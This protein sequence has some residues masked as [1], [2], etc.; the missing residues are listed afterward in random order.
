MSLRVIVSLLLVLVA[1]MLGSCAGAGIST[2]DDANDE[3]NVITTKPHFLSLVK[4]L[5][6]PRVHTII[7]ESHNADDE[8]FL[9]KESFLAQRRDRRHEFEQRLRDIRWKLLSNPDN[10]RLKKKAQ[11]YEKKIKELWSEELNERQHLEHWLAGQEKLDRDTSDT[12]TD[13][14]SEIA[15]VARSEVDTSVK[16]ALRRRLRRS[17]SNPGDQE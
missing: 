1:A 3:H 10:D 5:E 7:V 17:E 6:E 9:Q 13:R 14:A 11:A 4:T 2:I 8:T 15:T 12:E 16:P